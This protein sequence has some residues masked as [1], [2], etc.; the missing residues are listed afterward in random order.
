MF[1]KAQLE[2]PESMD[3]TDLLDSANRLL[4][5]NPEFGDAAE[6]SKRTLAYWVAEGLIPRRSG[7]GPDTQYS[8]HVVY[9][10]L[11][12]R[13]LQQKGLPL[14]EIKA[15]LGRL[16]DRFDDQTI[17][18]VLLG[19]ETLEVGLPGD[20]S[21]DEL[22][23][24]R[25]A[26]EQIEYLP[27]VISAENAEGNKETL[28]ARYGGSAVSRG[29]TWQ[30]DQSAPTLES[31]NRRSYELPI[32]EFGTLSLARKPDAATRRRIELLTKLLEDL[33]AEDK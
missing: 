33:L 29:R 13:L 28:G 10:L 4:S 12:I 8:K 1:S 26:G 23:K 25:A 2:L 21:A 7:R 30:A 14:K 6:I 24:R 15:E 17:E 31:N 19:Q 16:L 3:R 5:L 27:L 32:G 18:R 22:A 20:Y 9:R 11:F